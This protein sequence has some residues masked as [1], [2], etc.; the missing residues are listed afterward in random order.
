[1]T[2]ALVAA[3]RY[4]HLMER[5]NSQSWDAAGYTSDADKA[6]QA[7]DWKHAA[8]TKLKDEARKA[9]DAAT[10]ECLPLLR[11]FAETLWVFGPDK[12]L[13]LWPAIYAKMAS[14]LQ[15][16]G[17]PKKGSQGEKVVEL[18]KQGISPEGI[19]DRLKCGVD[20]VHSYKSRFSHLLNSQQ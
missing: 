10:G 13:P 7:S 17:K 18:L 16:K 15:K 6:L 3:V 2:E 4:Y 12:A 19:H 14:P 5:L 1:M 20:A 11:E 8:L 9:A